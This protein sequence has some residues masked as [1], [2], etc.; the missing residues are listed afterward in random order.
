MTNKEKFLKLVSEEKSDIL[1]K[2]KERIIHREQLRESQ[3]IALKVLLR[4]DELGWNQIKLAEEMGVHPQQ[5]SRLLKGK[6]NV[7][8][9]TLLKLQHALDIPL[10]ASYYERKNKESE[11]LSLTFHK[12]CKAIF[13]Q[14]VQVNNYQPIKNLTYEPKEYA[15]ALCHYELVG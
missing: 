2:N 13:A 14:T 11:E 3:Q 12:K 5:I 8:I 10:L 1:T 9:E 4:M 6:Q 15:P 7:T